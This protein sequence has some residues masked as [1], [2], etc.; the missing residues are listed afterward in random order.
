MIGRGTRGYAAY[1]LTTRRFTW[2]KDAWRTDYDGVEKE[3]DTLAKLN[4][5]NVQNVPTLVC[6][7]DILNHVTETPDF[8]DTR[9]LKFSV[10]DSPFIPRRAAASSSSPS[11]GSQGNKGASGKRKRGDDK[12]KASTTATDSQHRRHKHYRLVVE[13]VCMSIESFV[14][15]AMPLS[16]V[17]NCIG[18]KHA[19]NYYVYS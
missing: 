15:G 7:G 18:G 14:D 11:S 19:Q 2:L 6:H 13:E 12:A 8:C 10:P 16:I 9:L 17:Y 1:D 3:G 5:A 4:Q